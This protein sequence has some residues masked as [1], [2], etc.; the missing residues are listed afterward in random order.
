M[1]ISVEMIMTVVMSLLGGGG[2]VAVLQIVA[3][4]KRNKSEVTDINVKTA[5]ELERMAMS[6]YVEASESLGNAQKLLSEAKRELQDAK[7][8]LAEAKVELSNATRDYDIYRRHC[9]VL[10]DLLRSNNIAIPERPK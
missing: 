7:K 5:I 1:N 4:R 9:I 10:E 8:E 6:R 2:L 3:N